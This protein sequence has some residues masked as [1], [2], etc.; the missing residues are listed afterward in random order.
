V[1]FWG[2]GAGLLSGGAV[3]GG[4]GRRHGL[5]L[6]GFRRLAS[7]DSALDGSSRARTKRLSAAPRTSSMGVGVDKEGLDFNWDGNVIEE[8]GRRG[9][10]ASRGGVSGVFCTRDVFCVYSPIA[11]LR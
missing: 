1:R 7:L 4:N 6:R 11:I 5:V 10:A 3:A 8:E 9:V 2:Y